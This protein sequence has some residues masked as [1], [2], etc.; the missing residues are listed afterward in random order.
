LCQLNRWKRAVLARTRPCAVSHTGVT[1]ELLRYASECD[2][3]ADWNW[4]RGDAAAAGDVMIALHDILVATDFG[5]AA[6]G[7]L[8][9]G[10]ELA[11][12][13]GGRL[14]LLH[15]ADNSFLRARGADRY[16]QE[17]PVLRRLAEQLTEDDLDGLKANVVLVTSD[18][19]ADAIAEYASSSN[20]DLIVIGTNTRGAMTRRVV[21]SVAERV[22]R[23]APC[24]VLTVQSPEHRFALPDSPDALMDA[25]R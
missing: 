23:T 5:P 22:V 4:A 10:R 3:G 16:V 25:A 24:P 7:A 2:A 11:R 1:R 6:A 18:N 8:T 9:Y 13:F 12:T 14:H 21:G 20:I 15:V 19:A 17:A